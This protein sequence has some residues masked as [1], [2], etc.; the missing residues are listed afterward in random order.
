MPLQACIMSG[1]GNYEEIEGM[2]N[3][4]VGSFAYDREVRP[5]MTPYRNWDLYVV[6][7]HSMK[8]S[9]TL[10]LLEGVASM[11]RSYAS[12]I[13]AVWSR[14][15]WEQLANV[16]PDVINL[17]NCIFC[18]GPDWVTQMTKAIRRQDR[19]RRKFNE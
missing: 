12:R 9:D 14:E 6:D 2:L 1:R 10:R 19:L 8:P 17:S 11:A 15:T 7:T 3:L 18:D 16:A 5:F 13:V 4:Y